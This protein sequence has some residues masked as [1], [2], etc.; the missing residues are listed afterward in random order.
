MATD[1]PLPRTVT[2]GLFPLLL[3]AAVVAVAAASTPDAR[4]ARIPL[5][6]VATIGIAMIVER[7]RPL[8]R[9]WGMTA[10]GLGR[11]DLPYIGAGLVLERVSE[12]AV[13][14]IA[15]R[16][17][18]RGGFG[19]AAQLPMGLQVVVAIVAFDL[20]WYAYHRAAHGHDRLWRVHGAHHAPGQLYVLVHGVFHPFDE[21][22]VR[23][24]LALAVY[25]F[26]GFSPMATPIALTIV[27]VIGILSHV[28]ADV[29]LWALNHVFVGPETHRYHHSADHQVNFG[30]ATSLWDQVFGTFHF[31]PT[32]PARLGLARPEAYPDIERF[33]RVL[34]WPLQRERQ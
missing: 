14:A 6:L 2:Y 16:T 5:V 34:V 30:T 12:I 24:V 4:V 23:F 3:G 10:R 19:P 22:V 26:G 28:N 7:W 31:A 32:P 9:R 17:L 25:R 15:R 1:R 18:P 8:E 20:L 29:R 27:G 33:H 21:L 13:A 11:R